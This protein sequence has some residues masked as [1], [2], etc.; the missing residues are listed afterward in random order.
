M[1]NAKGKFEIKFRNGVYHHYEKAEL[2]QVGETSIS[3]T[4]GRY[5]HF[6]WLPDITHI[7][8]G[9]KTMLYEAKNEDQKA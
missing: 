9:T 1:L 5:K 2:K 4:E 3:V 7:K 6:F 8:R